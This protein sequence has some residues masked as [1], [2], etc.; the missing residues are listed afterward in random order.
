MANSCTTMLSHQPAQPRKCMIFSQK[1]KQSLKHLH[2]ETVDELHSLWQ[3]FFWR[4]IW[5]TYLHGYYKNLLYS[6]T[7]V[8][9]TAIRCNPQRQRSEEQ[10]IVTGRGQEE[11]CWVVG[12]ILFLGMHSVMFL[13][14][15]KYTHTYITYIYIYAYMYVCKY[16]KL[17]MKFVIYVVFYYIWMYILR[18][19]FCFKRKGMVEKKF[20]FQDC[21]WPWSLRIVR[22]RNQPHAFFSESRGP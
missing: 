11:A 4:D 6:C 7:W 8:K 16:I 10:G 12:N 3:V 17:F 2:L 20:P 13:G 18:Y 9:S 5:V 22:L 19:I 15:Y 14:M 21:T 1:M